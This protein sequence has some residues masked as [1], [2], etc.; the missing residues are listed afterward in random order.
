MARRQQERFVLSQDHVVPPVNDYSRAS[1]RHRQERTILRES[2]L[3]ARKRVPG[4][5]FRQRNKLPSVGVYT[6]TG[7][8]ARFLLE[9]K[10]PA[11]YL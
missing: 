1:R 7:F 2:S 9:C 11:I 10:T 3:L 4:A 5:L 6:E 8:L